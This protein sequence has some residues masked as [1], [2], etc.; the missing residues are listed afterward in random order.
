MRKIVHFRR[1]MKPLR[2]RNI[3]FNG[4]SPSPSS[5][6]APEWLFASAST[7]ETSLLSERDKW[8][9][10]I[11]ST[12]RDAWPTMRP[13]LDASASFPNTLL[14]NGKLFGHSPRLPSSHAVNTFCTSTADLVVPRHLRKYFHRRP[15]YLSNEIIWNSCILVIKQDKNIVKRAE[16]E[17]KMKSI[18]NHNINITRNFK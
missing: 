5:S 10:S 1:P 17:V 11:V 12:P 9:F 16:Y 2:I 18:C 15:L 6:S 13:T 3:A 8:F 4:S 7:T 14:A